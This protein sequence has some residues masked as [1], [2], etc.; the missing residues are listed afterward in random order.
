MDNK[1]NLKLIDE[2]FELVKSGSKRVEIRLYDEKRR[3]FKKDDT[4]SFSKLSNENEKI[5]A[6]V[7][8]VSVYETFSE[9]VNK[10]QLEDMYFKESSKEELLKLLNSIYSKEDEEKYGVCA[11]IFELKK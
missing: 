3:K 6:K 9:L 10:Y 2:V 1:M 11:I 4:F 5:Y 7:I 8:D